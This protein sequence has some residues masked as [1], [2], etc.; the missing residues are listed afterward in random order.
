MTCAHLKSC[1]KDSQQ[2]NAECEK[3]D[4]LARAK[5]YFV[6]KIDRFGVDGSCFSMQVP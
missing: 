1:F 6:L 2:S 4:F 3:K 5:W